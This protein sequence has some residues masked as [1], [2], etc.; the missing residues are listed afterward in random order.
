M[1]MKNLFLLIITAFFFSFCST[2]QKEKE[3][4]ETSIEMDEDSLLNLVQYQTFQYFWDG[5]EPNSGLARK[6]FMK[7]ISILLMISI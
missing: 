6:G 7:M 1:E 4:E 5:A 3:K 2:P